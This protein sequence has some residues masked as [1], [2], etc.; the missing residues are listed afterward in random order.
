MLVGELDAISQL[1]GEFVMSPEAE[2]FFHDEYTDWWENSKFFDE[3]ISRG[4]AGRRMHIFQKRSWPSCVEKEA[5][6]SNMPKP[7]VNY[8]WSMRSSTRSNGT[9]RCCWRKRFRGSLHG[10]KLSTHAKWAT[11]I[12][13]RRNYTRLTRQSS[14]PLPQR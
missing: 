4:L 7:G 6:P 9:S 14:E 12:S 11:D 8:S 5:W 1:H 2:K 13:E 3:D 10:V